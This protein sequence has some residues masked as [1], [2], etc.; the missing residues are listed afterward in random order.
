MTTHAQRVDDYVEYLEGAVR[1]WMRSAR[2]WK[3]IKDAAG[4]A[5]AVARAR[6]MHRA[7]RT[8]TRGRP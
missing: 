5:R 3:Q 1:W 8:Y 2:H 7:Y 4:V 6:D